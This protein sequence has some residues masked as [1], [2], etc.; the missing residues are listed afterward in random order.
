[1]WSIQREHAN[2]RKAPA[3]VENQEPSCCENL[4]LQGLRPPQIFYFW[5]QIKLLCIS[6]VLENNEAKIS[7]L[8]AID[9]ISDTTKVKWGDLVCNLGESTLTL[10]AVMWNLKLNHLWQPNEAGGGFLNTSVLLDSH[11]LNV[12]NSFQIL[13]FKFKTTI[14]ETPPVDSTCV[15]SFWSSAYKHTR[16]VLQPWNEMFVF[17][18]ES[19]SAVE[20]MRED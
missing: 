4:F 11:R 2:S 12:E 19:S 1:M 15:K 5:A 10:E 20:D 6:I 8:V 18:A 9:L 7:K 3:R 13:C 17:C 14:T 16:F